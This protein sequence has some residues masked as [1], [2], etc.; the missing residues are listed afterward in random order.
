[1]RTNCYHNTEEKAFEFQTVVG[2]NFTMEV[3]K[4]WSETSMVKMWLWRKES[5]VWLGN[6]YR[7]ENTGGYA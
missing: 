4:I 7:M 3:G 1:M 6:G 5:I 2:S